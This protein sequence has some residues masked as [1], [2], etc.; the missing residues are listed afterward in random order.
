MLVGC[1]LK[2]WA[3]TLLLDAC[4]TQGG[5]ATRVGKYGAGGGGC[6]GS[7]K[8]LGGGAM[9]RFPGP[10]GLS[11]S[12]NADKQPA[13]PWGEGA[14]QRS[15]G[16]FGLSWSVNADKQPAA[17]LVD[18]TTQVFPGLFGFPG[19]QPGCPSRAT[20]VKTEAAPP[21]AFVP[22]HEAA[23]AREAPAKP[24]R[25]NARANKTVRVRARTSMQSGAAL[26]TRP[27]LLIP[28]PPGSA[29]IP[30]IA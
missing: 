24:P 16:P 1:G 10:F 29:V 4:S 7:S 20:D 18:G 28:S 22:E 11:W 2:T 23:P 26:T 8:P 27:R 13:A 25:V 6:G 19:K 15:P 9:Q 14:T 17:P 3:G 30:S 12:V 21:Q 5:I